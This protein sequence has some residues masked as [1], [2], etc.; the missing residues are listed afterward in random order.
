MDELFSTVEACGT[1]CLLHSCV[2]PAAAAGQH[3][4]LSV[5]KNP[6]T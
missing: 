5:M 1:T 3:T 4:A 6:R 2:G